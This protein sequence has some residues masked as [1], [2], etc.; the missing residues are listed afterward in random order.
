MKHLIKTLTLAKAVG[1]L[2]LLLNSP[3]TH[4][5][6]AAYP[7][8]NPQPALQAA[9]PQTQV[10][11]ANYQST[12]RGLPQGVESQSTDWRSANDT[13]GQFKRGHID[14]LKLENAPPSQPRSQP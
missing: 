4:A 8:A 13:V 5:Q 7:R 6:H 3:A 1:L 12:L 14:L 2:V 9:S 11:L 10:P